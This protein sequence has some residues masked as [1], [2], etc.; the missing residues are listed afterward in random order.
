VVEVDEEKYI[1]EYNRE[2][3]I[4]V[5]EDILKDMKGEDNEAVLYGVGMDAVAFISDA[6]AMVDRFY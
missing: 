6:Y 4:E 3:F 1:Y 2:N 5:F